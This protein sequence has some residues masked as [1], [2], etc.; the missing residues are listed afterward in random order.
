M[1]SLRPPP[2]QS[3]PLWLVADE[4]SSATCLA[5]SGAE[6]PQKKTRNVQV[7]HEPNALHVSDQLHAVVPCC[8]TCILRFWEA[9]SGS[10]KA[11]KEARMCKG[12]PTERQ[13]TG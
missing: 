11:M 10:E 6:Q 8:V 12:C 5:A 3:R 4:R 2:K 13:S 1:G 9:Y 7:L